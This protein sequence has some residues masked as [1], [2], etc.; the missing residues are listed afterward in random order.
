MLTFIRITLGIGTSACA[1]MIPSSHADYTYNKDRGKAMA[2]GGICNG[3]GAT[4]A[5]FIYLKLPLWL[6]TTTSLS[7]AQAGVVTFTAISV[8]QIAVT[9][10]AVFFLHDGKIFLPPQETGSIAVP[11]E[12]LE[13]VTPMISNVELHDVDRVETQVA[14][15]NHRPI[16]QKG[17]LKLLGEGIT[18]AIKDPI[19]FLSYCASFIGRGDAM[20]ITTFIALWVSQD[21]L[22]NDS[23]QTEALSLAGLITGITQMFAFLSGILFGFLADRFNKVILIG[24]VSLVGCVG[25]CSTYLLTSVT[26]GWVFISV[27][28]IGFGEAGVFLLSQTL[29]TQGK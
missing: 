3:L 7:E 2:I 14:L 8:V 23:T 11:T 5:L 4:T 17:Y 25:Y 21:A 26:T 20:V 24:I 12:E 28:L 15:S 10:L 18:L 13:A 16:P 27:L 22:A 1:N 6:S 29:V 9:L 19:I